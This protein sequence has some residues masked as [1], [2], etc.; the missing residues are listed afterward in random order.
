LIF[1]VTIRAGFSL[2]AARIAES[3]LVGQGLAPVEAGR[4]SWRSTGM[5]KLLMHLGYPKSA[6]TTLQNGL[7]LELHKMQAINFIGRA[8]ESGY[9]GPAENKQ[10]YK[11][12]FRSVYQG[13]NDAETQRVVDG[14]VLNF[15]EDR[16]NVLSEGLFLTHEKHDDKLI[17]PEKIGEYFL[18][19]VDKA[20]L[21][22]VVRNQQTLIMSNYVQGYRKIEEKTFSGYLNE[23]IA[24]NRKGKF[25]I[26][27][28][29]NLISRY[30]EVMGKENI[31]IVFFEDLLNDK[32]TFH[33]ELGGVL[34]VNPELVGELLAR[35]YL[36]KTPKGE[37]GSVVRK[38]GQLS[39]GERL[40]R[41]LDETRLFAGA[42]S[43][44]RNKFVVPG[45]TDE[46]KRRI[47]DTFKEGNLKLAEEFQLDKERM[48]KY[49]YF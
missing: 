37:Q 1:S 23:M 27:Y 46:E 21:L 30:A 45:I 42:S 20:E 43:G 6:S 48:K 18:G 25:K 35:A 7:F 47:F 36:N 14:I 4:K 16:L 40:M 39:F 32:E 11:T 13:C 38:T 2:A 49:G 34:G 33:R 19:K 24:T 29:N 28:F 5:K 17:I 3:K 10:D 41:R 8:F 26:F 15:S 22:F 44:Q 12:W 31:N 9:Y